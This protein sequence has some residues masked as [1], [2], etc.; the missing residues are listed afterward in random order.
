MVLTGVLGTIK[1]TDSTRWA[2]GALLII[3]TFVYDISIGPVCYSLVAEM[4]STR[5]RSKTVVLARNLYNCGG[6][7]VSILNPYMLNPT[8]WN[9][10]PKSG[11]L[12]AGTGF[13]GLVWTFFRLPEPKGRS[14][15]E[16]ELL[17]EA[18]VPARKFKSTHVDEF[19]AAERDA[20]AGVTGGA[21]AH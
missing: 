7:V 17:F 18:R 12:W 16:L 9:W 5:L 15:G 3:F 6:V 21:I 11:Y 10:G 19:K 20:A 1:A 13:L 14:Y 8:A 4:G 2:I